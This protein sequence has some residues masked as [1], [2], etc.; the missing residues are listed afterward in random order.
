MIIE[1]EY[2]DKL[3]KLLNNRNPGWIDGDKEGNPNKKTADIVNDDLKIAIEI[4]DDTKNKK[5]KIPTDGTIITSSENLTIM[6]KRMSDC[7]KDANNKFKEYPEYKTIL[8]L[9]T[10]FDFPDLIRYAFEGLHTYTKKGDESPHYSGRTGKYS[11]H[12]KK[13]VGS[14]IVD[15][16]NFGFFENRYA[17]KSRKIKK[18]E[19]ENIFNKKIKD[20]EEI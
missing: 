17:K 10:N 11:I 2:K 1:K 12:A 4:K 9:R 15:S 13:E 18:E 14:I 16:K 7:L 19:V 8:I 20:I 6:N 3:I 5:I